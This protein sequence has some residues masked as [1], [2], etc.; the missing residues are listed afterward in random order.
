MTNRDAHGQPNPYFG[1]KRRTE[2]DIAEMLGLVK[3]ILIDGAVS[4]D[5]AI[6]LVNWADDHPDVVQGWPGD[7]VYRRLRQIFADGH[8]SEP[9]REDL[10][11]LLKSLVGGE[12]GMINAETAST[13]LPFEDPLPLIEIPNRNFVFTGRFA[14]GTR[15][16]CHKAVKSLGGWAEKG[17]NQSVDFL[18][19]GTFASRDWAQTSYGRKIEKAVEMREK[20]GFIKIVPEEHWV[21]SL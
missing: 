13:G 20:D 17:L 6:A 21:A 19:I 11:E 7:V 5:E 8:A 18:V 10:A 14:F 2:R 16:A 4:E 9:E 12:A 15:A 3:G 1:A